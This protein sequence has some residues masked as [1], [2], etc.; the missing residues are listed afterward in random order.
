MTD[1]LNQAMTATMKNRLKS[2]SKITSD[3]DLPP[4]KQ[5]LSTNLEKVRKIYSRSNARFALCA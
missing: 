2:I 4:L 3:Q 5:T 1:R